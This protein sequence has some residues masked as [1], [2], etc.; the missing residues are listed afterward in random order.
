M[1]PDISFHCNDNSRRLVKEAISAGMVE[2]I[3]LSSRVSSSSLE[4]VEI[5][6]GMGPARP[7]QSAEPC[8]NKM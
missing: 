5:S 2:V 1:G 7:F 4:S 3:S 6:P 8:T